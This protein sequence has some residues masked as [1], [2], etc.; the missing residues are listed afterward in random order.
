[1]NVRDDGAGTMEAVYYGTSTGGLFP[2]HKGSG[3]GPWIMADLENGLWGGTTTINPENHPYP[4]ASFVTAM[5]KGRRDEF[6]L[7]GGDAQLPRTLDTLFQGKR[8]SKYTPMKKQGAILLG[9]GGDNSNGGIG[10]FYEGVLTAGYSPDSADN[11]VSENIAAAGY[12]L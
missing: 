10:T 8:P 12:G 1:M 11:E 9:I 3:S 7:K 5:V 6:T 2:T 4:N